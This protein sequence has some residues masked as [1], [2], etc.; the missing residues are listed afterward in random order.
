MY[1]FCLVQRRL[2]FTENQI[3]QA[4]DI[5]TFNSLLLLLFFKDVEAV[6]CL[7][8]Q[9]TPAADLACTFTHFEAETAPHH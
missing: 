4:Y 1:L 3:S 5:H 8:L 9:G 6:W 7:V 2:Q